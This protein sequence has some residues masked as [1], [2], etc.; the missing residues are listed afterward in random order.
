MLFL[1]IIY[2]FQNLMNSPGDN[3]FISVFIEI[4]HFIHTELCYYLHMFRLSVNTEIW[5]LPAEL[6]ITI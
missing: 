5:C 1:F 4:Q 6:F 3:F 2:Y